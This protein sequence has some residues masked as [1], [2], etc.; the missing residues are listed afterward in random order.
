MAT[1]QVILRDSK[2]GSLSDEI[3]PHGSVVEQLGV[4]ASLLKRDGFVGESLAG[5]TYTCGI[6]APAY[7]MWELFPLLSRL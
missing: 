5:K 6:T 3:L 1:S 2:L 4:A 7:G